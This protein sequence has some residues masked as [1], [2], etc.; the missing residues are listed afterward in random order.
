MAKKYY[1]VTTQEEMAALFKKMLDTGHVA[2]DVRTSSPDPMTCELVGLGISPS[3]KTGFYIPLGH[4]DAPG[5]SFKDVEPWISHVCGEEW[6]TTVFFDTVNA[7][8]VLERY[9]IQ[10]DPGMIYDVLV[11]Q[12]GIDNGRH[13]RFAPGDLP[14]IVKRA[15]GHEIPELTDIT[16]RGKKR[17]PYGEVPIQ[18]AF[19]YSAMAADLCMRLYY[20]QKEPAA[21]NERRHEHI[22][23][24]TLPVLK[25]MTTNGI[26]IDM[27]YLYAMKNAVENEIIREQDRLD[28]Y[29]NREQSV[30]AY[31]EL[32]DL[33]FGKLKL[34]PGEGQVRNQSDFFGTDM[35]HLTQIEGQHDVVPLI[36]NLRHCYHALNHHLEPIA[37]RCLSGRIHTN[38]NPITASTRISSYD[39]PLQNI[40]LH[41]VAG[42]QVRKAFTVPDGY[43]WVQAD[44]SQVE[45][46]IL[47]DLIVCQFGD[48]RYAQIFLD[49][50][51][52]H[53]ATAAAIFNVLPKKVTDHQ[54][55]I[56]KTINFGLIYGMSTYGL[57]RK[58]SCSQSEAHTFFMGYLNAYPGVGQWM[59]WQKKFSR[60][61]G[62]VETH[63]FKTRRYTYPGDDSVALNHPVQGGAGEVIRK[64]LIEVQGLL[65][66][67]AD[68]GALMLLQVHDDVSLQVPTHMLNVFIPLLREIMTHTFELAGSLEVEISTGKNWAELTPWEN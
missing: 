20:H 51:D 37:K 64:V 42:H 50:G 25:Q 2:I 67:R 10:V 7:L 16:G 46:R 57:Q 28:Q 33:L 40:P 62:Y 35:E 53:I 23:F 13:K 24:P 27:E 54:R 26:Q 3:P 63:L 45:L 19:V 43:T 9:G 15:L 52:P 60:E 56:A 18:N 38:F 61:H 17:L 34:I 14:Y 41:T 39:P 21:E 44:Y 58:L 30:Y 1:T 4:A 22:D 59:D 8:I 5:L 68:L 32:S 36:V 12:N 11:V 47:A 29:A 48:W 6:I 49:G 31:R 55:K 65:Y 66:E